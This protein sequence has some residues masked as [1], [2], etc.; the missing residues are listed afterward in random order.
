MKILI[1]GIGNIL[2]SDEGIGVHIVNYM[3]EKYTLSTH[4]HVDF[5]DG[6][7]L[8]QHLIPVIV[9]YD[10]LIIIDTV[11]APGVQKG[12]V[13]FFDFEDIPAAVDWQG[14]AHEVEMLQ[15][16]TMMDLVGDR[17]VTKIIGI[18]PTVI[19]PISFSLSDAVYHSVVTVE[20]ILVEHLASM[21]IQM[22]IK[23]KI[24][25]DDILPLS[26]KMHDEYSL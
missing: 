11:N 16:L 15:T 26:Y 22:D 1:L 4:H 10:Y 17:P 18:V 19:E 9:Q 8:A 21:D 2:F 6:G 7:T 5:M 25:I 12:E 23:K 14:S 3:K 13:Y 20:S 24:A